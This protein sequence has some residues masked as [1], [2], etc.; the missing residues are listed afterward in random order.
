MW[1]RLLRLRWVRWGYRIAELW[2]QHA[3]T[4]HS[5]GLAFFSL[6]TL[7][8]LLVVLA[9]IGGYFLGS[10]RIVGQILE[11]VEQTLGEG[12]TQLVRQIIEQTLQRGSGATATLV[13]LLLAFWG[14]SGLLQALKDSLDALWE[15]P[16]HAESGLLHWL[17]ARLIATGGVLLLVLLLS[18]SLLLEVVLVSL[19]E[20]L[21]ESLPG[22]YWLGYG[23]NRALTPL[24]LWIGIAL[25][26]WWLPAR[27]PR[28]REALIG[29]LVATFLV[30]G[31]RWFISWYLATTGIATLYG[32]A[33]SVVVLLLGVYFGAQAF[34]LGATVSV[35][36]SKRT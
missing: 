15:S 14:A 26:Y 6:L 5:A 11:G 25:F 27:R 8:P 10:E 21:P 31:L 24:L 18:L 32:S 35:V 22:V 33:G 1:T 23:L 28:F 36:V 34:L 20:R 19:Q 9:G 4:R 13:G 30:V 3:L 7:T 16:P 29:A 17:I 12:A 2:S